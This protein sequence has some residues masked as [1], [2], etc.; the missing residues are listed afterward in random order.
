MATQQESVLT[1]LRREMKESPL[2]APVERRPCNRVL[3]D[4]YVRQSM[5]EPM[6]QTKEYRQRKLRKA[7]RV[8]IILAILAL[9]ALAVIKAGII[10]V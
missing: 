10:R 9:C 7:I 6:Y 4:G 3:A 2:P 5:E 8:L 1:L